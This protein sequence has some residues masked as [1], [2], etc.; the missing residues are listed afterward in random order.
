MSISAEKQHANERNA[1]HSTGPRTAE[2]KA[3]SSRNATRHGLFSRQ[4]LLP[5]EDAAALLAMREGLLRRLNPRDELERQIVQHYIACAWKLQRLQSAEHEAYMDEIQTMK[6]QLSE[7][8]P[9]RAAPLPDPETGLV[10]WRMM[11]GKGSALERLSRHEQRLWNTM[12]RCL[13]DL[14]KLQQQEIDAPAVDDSA[15]TADAQNEP[16]AEQDTVNCR[17]EQGLYRAAWEQQRATESLAAE[18]ESNARPSEPPPD[19]KSAA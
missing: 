11:Q 12:Q 14:E 6:Q 2:G 1:Q 9:D 16:T 19:A 15:A 13:R 18:I 7:M 10:M 3:R 4:L 8:M 17:D 5:G